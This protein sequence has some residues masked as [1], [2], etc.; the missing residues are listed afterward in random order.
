MGEKNLQKRQIPKIFS[1][2]AE[3]R[4]F[5]LYH[6][7]N[8]FYFLKDTISKSAYLCKS[9]RFWRI[10]T[11]WQEKKF[12]LTCS[13][14]HFYPSHVHHAH[15]GFHTLIPSSYFSCVTS[16]QVFP[17][18]RAN[19]SYLLDGG[20][21]S[22]HRWWKPFTLTSHTPLCTHLCV[23]RVWLPLLFSTSNHSTTFYL[24]LQW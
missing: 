8:Q 5:S 19:V 11:F 21:F 4:F 9:D 16:A 17:I 14:G 1:Q 15:N 13:L 6:P 10:I 18:G 7:F 2:K 22:E 12:S 3:M 24:I 20:Y 23:V